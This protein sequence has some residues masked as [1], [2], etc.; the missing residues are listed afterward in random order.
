MPALAIGVTLTSTPAEAMFDGTLPKETDG[1]SDA[2]RT[3]GDSG[4]GVGVAVTSPPIVTVAVAV[5]TA[6]GDAVAVAVGVG[7]GCGVPEQ[8]LASM[9]IIAD[10]EPVWPDESVAT[11]VRL[12]ETQVTSHGIVYVSLY[13]FVLTLPICHGPS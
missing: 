2:M 11:A 5:A 9:S 10:D 4:A 7:V 6:V 13:G 12:R 1:P 3:A 8:S